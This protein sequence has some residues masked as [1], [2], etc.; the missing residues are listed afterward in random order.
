[1]IKHNHILM[2]IS[3][4]IPA[5]KFQNIDALARG[6]LKWKSIRKAGVS[7]IQDLSGSVTFRIFPPGNDRYFRVNVSHTV[8]QNVVTVASVEFDSKTLYMVESTLYRGLPVH[9]FRFLWPN[10][11]EIVMN[12]T[13]TLQVGPKT[14]IAFRNLLAKNENEPIAAIN[15]EIFYHLETNK[16]LIRHNST[17][18]VE[19]GTPELIA[20]FEWGNELHGNVAR[21][22][23]QIEFK[24]AGLLQIQIPILEIDSRM[25][26]LVGTYFG[27]QKVTLQG[28]LLYSRPMSN[29]KYGVDFMCELITQSVF[30]VQS[31]LDFYLS[32]H[33]TRSSGC[34][35][36]FKSADS[37]RTIAL[38]CSKAS[39]GSILFHEKF[40]RKS[41]LEMD[42]STMLA[43][44]PNNPTEQ[45]KGWYS[46]YN[47]GVAKFPLGLM[48]E[49]RGEFTPNS[50]VGPG[51]P[52][53]LYLQFTG[54]KSYRSG[55]LEAVFNSQHIGFWTGFEMGT[56][57]L[58]YELTGWEAKNEE[59]M[60][61][62]RAIMGFRHL[63]GRGTRAFE[64]GF[65]VSV[66]PHSDKFHI[67]LQS[68][69][70]GRSQDNSI[71]FRYYLES[72][73][74]SASLDI[75][76]FSLMECS[77]KSEVIYDQSGRFGEA[78][79][80]FIVPRL[81]AANKVLFK[82]DGE[83]VKLLVVSNNETYLDV[84]VL[85]SENVPV[86]ADN[87]PVQFSFLYPG[88]SITGSQKKTIR[89]SQLGWKARNHNSFRALN[90][91]LDIGQNGDKYKY[92]VFL[93][94]SSGRDRSFFNQIDLKTT[95]PWPIEASFSFG[96][97]T[98]ESHFYRHNIRKLGEDDK[99]S[100]TSQ[101][102][103]S[104]DAA[105][106]TNCGMNYQS[107]IRTFNVSLKG[108]PEQ[109]VYHVELS[110][111][112]TRAGMIQIFL[113]G[114]SSVRLW[115]PLR[116]VQFHLESNERR[117]GNES[118]HAL[119]NYTIASWDPKS[120]KPAR[121]AYT[122]LL[123]YQLNDK[124]EDKRNWTY[125]FKLL[126]NLLSKVSRGS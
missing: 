79:L 66:S 72:T 50:G 70:P 12:T 39:F 62:A 3:A 126:S 105:Y 85:L 27:P 87:E 52:M 114:R 8:T 47:Y 125:G 68:G 13:Y 96:R 15:T 76:L 45:F 81:N 101:A 38:E 21:K 54:E 83:F 63:E 89:F 57:M 19:G 75:W 102:D 5:L 69:Q 100:W 78:K 25:D 97:K 49:I 35:F 31:N 51:S 40:R 73:Q 59:I 65:Q 82:R 120:E 16:L 119:T 23:L 111:D 64:S 109:S 4:L 122:T 110:W 116:R 93:G 17:K 55:N 74:T 6:Y 61:T 10:D 88:V 53:R 41:E 103:C 30:A 42:G 58:R 48:L 22:P 84:P 121:E 29:S 80:K 9:S 94:I 104:I 34:D 7:W 67:Q 46:N 92:S 33:P 91:S 28:R 20:G 107:Q 18:F 99:S 86:N 90:T 32:G 71:S 56:V 108:Q 26:A 11:Q 36:K 2:R 95:Y 124:T 44:I 43:I 112:R 123:V 77:V 115:T 106:A 1:M 60:L 118:V 14:A 117:L 24:A 98:K 37:A 113:K